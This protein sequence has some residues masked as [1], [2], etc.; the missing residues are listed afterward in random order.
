MMD[1][2]WK[3]IAD[4]RKRRAKLVNESLLWWNALGSDLQGELAMQSTS[5]EV[6]N[7][8][9]RKIFARACHDFFTAPE[10]AK[11]V[12]RI[13]IELQAIPMGTGVLHANT[14]GCS[15]TPAEYGRL[16]P[17]FE[18]TSRGRSVRGAKARLFPTI[19]THRLLCRATQL[20]ARLRHW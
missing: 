13:A 6:A 20:N 8:S 1:S 19:P 5:G 18:Q 10:M 12:E 2:A 15:R 16:Q 3:D 17:A 11:T 9:R 14:N 4:I 7:H